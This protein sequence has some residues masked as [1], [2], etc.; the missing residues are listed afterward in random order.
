MAIKEVTS[1]PITITPAAWPSLS[2]ALDHALPVPR[3][4]DCPAADGAG[5]VLRQPAVDAVHVV[6]VRAR[7][8]AELVALRVLGDA[9]AAGFQS[10]AL[11]KIPHG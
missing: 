4:Q 2:S 5:G 1:L 3:G 8:L 11:T 10:V 7:Q 6:L 9:H